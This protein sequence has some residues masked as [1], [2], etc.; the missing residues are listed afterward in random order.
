MSVKVDQNTVL[1][2]VALLLFATAHA[3]SEATYAPGLPS[4]TVGL[5]VARADVLNLLPPEHPFSEKS[6]HHVA[7]TAEVGKRSVLE[8]LEAAW[9]LVS[10]LPAVPG[11]IELV[12]EISDLLREARHVGQT[13]L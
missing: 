11:L 12:V 8:L 9:K 5:E 1:E 10:E 6:H 7:E 2:T 3:T 13:A 4:L